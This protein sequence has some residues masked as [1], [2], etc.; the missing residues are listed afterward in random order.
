[1]KRLLVAA[2]LLLGLRSYAQTIE[3]NRPQLEWMS[4]ETEHFIIHYVKGLEDV[5]SLAAQIAEEIHDPLCEVYDYRPDT[6]VSLIF[7]DEDDIANAGSYFQSNKIKFFATSMNWD[8][9]GT[10]NWLRNVVTHEYTHMIQLG[11]TRKWSRRLPAFYFQ[12]LGY[13]PERRPDVLYGYPNTLISWP[14][15]SVTIPAWFAEGTAQYQFK[16]SGYDFWDSHRDMLLRQATLSNR[17]LSWDDMC[18]FGKTSLESEGVYNQ[19]FSFVKFIADRSGGAETLNKISHKMS[20][21]WPVSINDAIASATGKRGIEWYRE[22]ESHLESSYGGR[23]DALEPF[24]STLDTIGTQGFV[25]TF[26]RFSP[27]GSKLAFISNED[28]DYFGQSSLCVWDAATDSV[29]L[30]APA[31]QGGLCW[32]PD[33]SGILF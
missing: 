27:D 22:W 9:R 28:R 16:G 12:L 11:A 19:G 13:E 25:N 29:E 4:F 10:H 23:R 14:L 15:P 3:Y 32:L 26:P 21:V 18:Y 31:A 1:M 17:L 2:L 33:A 5:A 8:F 6:K 24:I 30:L 20:S 7:S